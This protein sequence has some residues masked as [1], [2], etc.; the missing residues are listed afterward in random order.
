MT[1][2]LLVAVEDDP[3]LL[4]DVENELRGRYAQ[5]YRV[6]CLSSAQQAIARLKELAKAGEDVAVVLAGQRLSGT[7]GADLLGVVR[8]LHPLARLGLLIDWGVWGEPA[9]GGQIFDSIARGHID[10]YL[11]RPAGS[12]DENFHRTI[13]S[14][15]L[16]WAE[17]QHASPNSVFVVARTW[18]GRAFELRQTLGRCAVPHVF[19]LADTDEA[20]ALLAD[21][22]GAPSYPLIV[23][24]NGTIMSDPTDA[25]IALAVG[26]TVDPGGD[27]FDLVIIGSGPAGL[28]AA[29]YGASEGLRTLV[30]DRGGIGG[31]ATSSSSIRN[32]LGFPR[33]V[34]GRSLAR[35]AYEQAWVFGAGFAFMQTAT[36]IRRE[37]ER[38]LVT[39]SLGGVALAPAVVLATGASYR[40]LGVPELEA[41]NGAGV[42]YGAASSEAP[43]MTGQDVYVVGGGNSAG[44]AT[45]HLARYARRVTI[46]MRAAALDAEMSQYLVRQIEA[47]PNVRV[48]TGADVVGGGGRGWLQ[49]LDIRDRA[50][51]TQESV[52]AGGLFLMIGARPQTDWLPPEVQRDGNGF[53]VTGADLDEDRVAALGR[54][55]Y[56][57]ETSLPGLLAAGDVRHGSIKRVASAVGEG[58]V[59][60][61]NVHRLLAAN[62]AQALLPTPH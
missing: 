22:D 11:I 14:F 24:P 48:I 56:S 15:L 26:S 59:A 30:I 20:Q 2:P 8:R 27:E 45:L 1:G 31:Q 29:V 44:Q 38:L 61:Q 53:V 16:E 46:V 47:T 37:D 12:P 33:G 23:L 58:S 60:I 55:P 49:H 54:R 51:G 35:Q 10:H 62:Q 17:A 39:L 42:V 50:T 4:R 28:S 13:S 52:A 36:Q 40:R 6:E 19:L 7:S 5:H 43:A 9:T 3:R 41:L 21:A 25:E 32:Y 34:S 18:S 57:L